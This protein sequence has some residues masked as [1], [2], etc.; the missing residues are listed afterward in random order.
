MAVFSP[1]RLVL[2]GL[3]PP[4]DEGPVLLARVSSVTWTSD[5]RAEIL[6]V[7]KCVSRAYGGTW[8]HGTLPQAAGLM[9]PMAFQ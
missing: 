4:V 6:M 8:G 7:T 5:A 2:C 3:S 9:C 1:S